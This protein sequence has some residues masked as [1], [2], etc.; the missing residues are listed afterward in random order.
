MMEKTRGVRLPDHKLHLNMRLGM[1]QGTR[2]R[3]R[4][5]GPVK[6]EVS[7]KTIT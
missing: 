1:G 5:S 7:V 2:T 6:M 3:R 4:K